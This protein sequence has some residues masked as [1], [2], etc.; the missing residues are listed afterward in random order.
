MLQRLSGL[1]LTIAIAISFQSA[2][3]A[4]LDPLIRFP[5]FP[6]CG[7][8]KV[9]GKIIK[10]FNKAEDKTWHR[11]FYL[12][13][14]TRVRERKVLGDGYF[15]E[16]EITDDYHDTPM[17]E[18]LVPRRYC[19]GHAQLTNGRHPTLFYLIEGGQGFAGNSYNVEY[20]VNGLDPWREYD[21]S[22]RV[23]NH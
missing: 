18:R 1:L 14:I 21:G 11:G 7:D 2:S 23:L 10:R 6:Q 8:A 12:E 19:R 22:C 3:A 20:C 16:R 4:L 13:D 9:L 17:H 5:S 15:E